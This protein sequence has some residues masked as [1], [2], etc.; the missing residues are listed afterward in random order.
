MERMQTTA[1]VVDREAAV[2]ERVVDALRATGG[3][4]IVGECGDGR[5]AL[6]ALIADRPELLVLDAQTPGLSGFE[7]LAAVEDHPPAAVLVITDADAAVLGALQ[8]SGVDHLVRP[9]DRAALIEAV[10]RLRVDNGH[11]AVRIRRLLTELG[12]G[13]SWSDRLVIKRQRSLTLVSVSEIDWAEASGNYVRLHVGENLHRM[14]STLAALES[15]LDPARFLRI[16]R[17]IIVNADRVREIQPW[18]HGDSVV[19]L[20][21]GTRLNVSRGYRSNVERY[22]ARFAQ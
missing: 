8:R 17:S 4:E 10:A 13:P 12:H 5:A 15:R 3:Y 18:Y 9:V 16:H 11:D 14:R 6:G 20:E 22:L 2:R 7:I 1:L 21:D 19:V